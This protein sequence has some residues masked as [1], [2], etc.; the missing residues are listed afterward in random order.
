MPADKDK[1]DLSFDQEIRLAIPDL[2]EGA[3]RFLLLGSDKKRKRAATETAKKASTGPARKRAASDVGSTVDTTEVLSDDN[4]RSV[5]PNKGKLGYGNNNSSSDDNDKPEGTAYILVEVP[6]VP[7]LAPARGSSRSKARASEP[8]MSSVQR[9]PF[10]FPLS[11]SY[12]SFLEA[13]AASTPCGRDR[14]VVNKLFWRFDKPKNSGLK[15]LSD[16]AGFKAMMKALNERNKDHVIHIHM[17]RPKENEDQVCWDTGKDEKGDN[18]EFKLDDDEGKFNPGQARE[19]AM[20]LDAG[21]EEALD[22]LKEKFPVGNCPKFPEM[23]VYAKDGIYW[24]LNDLRLRVWAVHM[25]KGT[26]TIDNPP[27]STHFSLKASIKKIPSQPDVAPVAQPTIPN[28]MNAVFPPQGP[29]P[30]F[31]PFAAMFP[32]YMNPFHPFPIPAGAH[33][34]GPPMPNPMPVPAQHVD[35]IH[36]PV[37]PVTGQ[38]DAVILSP[39]VPFPIDVSLHDFCARYNISMADMAKLETLEVIPGDKAVELL[40]REDWGAAGFSKL[41]WDRFLVKHRLFRQDV[42][43]GKWEHD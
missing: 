11:I 1:P 35:P 9:G 43:A 6:R 30:P 13:L 19:Q 32:G 31:N 5:T 42:A 17:P 37:T 14:L 26:A 28:Y 20:G 36:R 7:A 2:P 29:Y 23:R 25:H 34:F 18:P 41:A 22:Q 40:G 24:E 15:A 27:A 33:P 4:S 12:D 39:G 10:F 8:T 21:S 16:S 38:A 3:R